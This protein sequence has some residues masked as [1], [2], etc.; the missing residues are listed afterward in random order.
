MEGRRNRGTPAKPSCTFIVSAC[1][2]GVNC[3]YRG[4]NKL[5]K[6]LKGLVALRGAIA[7][8]PEVMG[9]LPIPRENSEIHGGSGPDVLTGKAVVLT[10]S[11][12][13]VSANYVRGSKRILAIARKYGL[14]KA[15]LK[16]KSPACGCGIIYD[17]TF[18]RTLKK[19]DGVLTALLRNSGITVYTELDLAQ[20]KD[21]KIAR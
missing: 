1:L 11:G 3:T 10:R 18:S 21:L 6:Q 12:K 8:C 15:I 20:A 14:R 4:K 2:A 13:D 9:G 17:G 7:V 19:G 5:V 16:S